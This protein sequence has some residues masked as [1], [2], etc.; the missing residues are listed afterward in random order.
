MT[1]IDFGREPIEQGWQCPI[2]KRVYTPGV[3]MCFYCGGDAKITTK[4][5]PDLEETKSITK[6]IK[7]HQTNT[8]SKE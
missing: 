6:T 8:N 4:V 3:P 2:C 7:N 5:E 1:Y